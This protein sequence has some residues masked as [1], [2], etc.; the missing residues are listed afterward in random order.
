M[1]RWAYSSEAVLQ[2]I[3]GVLAVL[4]AFSSVTIALHLAHH[5]RPGRDASLVS[6]RASKLTLAATRE[7]SR[8]GFTD[9]FGRSHWAKRK[10]ILTA[11]PYIREECE[12]NGKNW[13]AAQ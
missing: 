7:A 12:N 1:E 13:R 3:G 10:D 6:P 9:T 11:L 4:R 2:A 5:C 8:I